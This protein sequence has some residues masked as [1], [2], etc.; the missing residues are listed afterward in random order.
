MNSIESNFVLHFISLPFQIRGKLKIW[1]K[2]KFRTEDISNKVESVKWDR[3]GDY[4]VFTTQEHEKHTFQERLSF[5]KPVR[6]TG[7]RH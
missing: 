5:S 2:P 1:S 6:V 4:Y 3:C 7:Y